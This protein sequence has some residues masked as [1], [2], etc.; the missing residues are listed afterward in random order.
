MAHN[1][2]IIYNCTTK[3][4]MRLN[5]SNAAVVVLEHPV[6]YSYTTGA[7]LRSP[8]NHTVCEFRCWR[9]VQSCES[10]FVFQ[11]TIFAWSRA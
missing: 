1:L 4:L 11:R 2:K 3:Y 6:Q 5:V 8:D 10:P 7:R 9:A